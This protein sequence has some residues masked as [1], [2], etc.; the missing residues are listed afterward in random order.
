[1]R[2]Y[3]QIMPNI[4]KRAAN[5][6]DSRIPGRRKKDSTFGDGFGKGHR[7]GCARAGREL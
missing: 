6:A 7:P 3:H 4:S 5:E 1:M 2:W